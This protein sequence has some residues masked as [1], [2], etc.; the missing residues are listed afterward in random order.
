ME[1]NQTINGGE[2]RME[3]KIVTFIS[4]CSRATVH[5]EVISAAQED[6]TQVIEEIN[7]Y[8]ILSMNAKSIRACK[9]DKFEVM[10]AEVSELVKKGW[11]WED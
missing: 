6:R 9:T 5:V 3:K 2:R 4:Q 11:V 7:G 1:K 8:T 10:K